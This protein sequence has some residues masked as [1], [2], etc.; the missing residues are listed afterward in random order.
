M[1]IARRLSRLE[2][3]RALHVGRSD[4]EQEARTTWAPIF[5]S[6]P[7]DLPERAPCGGWWSETS[8]AAIVQAIAVR[9]WQE[10]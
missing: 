9:E 7:G 5:R 8:Y 10:G 2:K 6:A 1:S 3:R 4:R